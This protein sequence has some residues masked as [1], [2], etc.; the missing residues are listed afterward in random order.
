MSFWKSDKFSQIGSSD[1]SFAILKC[2]A[3]ASSNLAS[4]TERRPVVESDTMATPVRYVYNCQTEGAA[5]V[6]ASGE[7]APSKD[8]GGTDERSTLTPDPGDDDPVYR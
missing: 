2:R 5:L 3:L 8:I 6:P 7:T 4:S 1:S